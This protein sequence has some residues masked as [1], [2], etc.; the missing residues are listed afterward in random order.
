[1]VVFLSHLLQTSMR[2]QKNLL[3]KES[4]SEETL[5]CITSTGHFTFLILLMFCI[6]KYNY[7]IEIAAEIA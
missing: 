1:M 3:G 6:T 5:T 7:Y 4:T 2:R